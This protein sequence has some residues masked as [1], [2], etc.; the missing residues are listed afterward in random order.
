MNEYWTWH[1]CY[2]GFEF[3]EEIVLKY[4]VLRSNGTL[5]WCTRCEDYAW[6][7]VYYSVYAICIRKSLD[8]SGFLF[9]PIEIINS[10]FRSYDYDRLV[11]TKTWLYVEDNNI[12]SELKPLVHAGCYLIKWDY[13]NDVPKVVE[14]IGL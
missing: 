12:V 7:S 6:P 14:G 13:H 5:S 1:C 2:C 9:L 10:R 4:T 11:R 8:G 3:N